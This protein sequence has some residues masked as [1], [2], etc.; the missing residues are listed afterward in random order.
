MKNKIKN[1]LSI[2]VVSAFFSSCVNDTFDTPTFECVS[3]TL[4]K[5]K[6]VQDIYNLAAITGNSSVKYTADDIIEAIVTSSDEGGNFFKTVSFISVDGLRGFSMS[7]DD[8]NLYTKKLQPGKKVYI[9]LKDL[10]YS[11]P[12]G[13][14]RGLVL[15]SAPTSVQNVDRIPALEYGKSLIPT[16]SVVD[17]EVL[18]KKIT[19]AQANNDALLNALV[20]IDNVQ[21]QSECATYSKKDFDTSLKIQSGSTLLDVRTSRFASFAGNSVPSGNGKIRG[22][23]TKYGTAYQLVLRN[24]RDVKM[25]NPR[26]GVLLPTPLGGSAIT[27]GSNFTENFEPYAVTT[28]GSA[29]PKNLNINKIGN[30]YWDIKL[31]SANKYAQMSAFNAGCAKALLLVPANMTTANGISFKTKDGFF[32]GQPLHVYYTT[33]FTPGGNLDQAT[34]VEITSNFALAGGTTT[35]YATNFTLSGQYSLPAEVT[36][37]GFFIFEYDGTTSITTTMQIDD[38]VIN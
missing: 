3:P 20:E 24:E 15:G 35:G 38:I 25:T 33:N 28:A 1:I 21:F 9:K 31:F 14:A 37:N 17:E 30:R 6:E 27:Y 29:M 23:L 10:Y 22:V 12:S 7:I 19:L 4:V 2:M 5:T 8:Y 26:V 16:C 18:V 13:F 32:D 11:L 34:L 36:G